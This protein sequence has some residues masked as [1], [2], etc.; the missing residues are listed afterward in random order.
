MAEKKREKQQAKETKNLTR[1]DFLK[2][3]S[4][5][6]AGTLAGTGVFGNGPFVF[7]RAL[8]A[9]KGKPIK[10]GTCNPLSGPVA[11]WGVSQRRCAELWAEEIKMLY[12]FVNT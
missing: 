10:I 9:K 8:A 11:L 1:R 2:T 3:S 5:I 6:A 4:V 12:G 7:S